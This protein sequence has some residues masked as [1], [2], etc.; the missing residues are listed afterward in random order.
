MSNRLHEPLVDNGCTKALFKYIAAGW[1][2]RAELDDDE[3]VRRHAEG[4]A[5]SRDLRNRVGNAVQNGGTVDCGLP[6]GRRRAVSG[7]PAPL[8]FHIRLALYRNVRVAL[9]ADVRQLWQWRSFLGHVR[10]YS[11]SMVGADPGVGLRKAS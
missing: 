8:R 5:S 11:L 9:N 4:L 2:P 6:P 10:P 7:A 3:T 1:I